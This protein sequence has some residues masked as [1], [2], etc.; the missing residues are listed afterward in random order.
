MNRAAK[1]VLA[2][3]GALYSAAVTARSIG[4]ERQF[5]QTHE[6]R[7]PVISVGNI[8]V[9]GTGKTPLVQWLARRLADGGRTVCILSRGYRRENPKQQIVVSNGETILSDVAH[10]GDEAIMLAQSLIGK[11]AIVCDADRVAGANWAV[12]HLHSRVLLLDDG[13]QH[14]RLARDLDIVTVDASNPFGNERLLPAGILREPIKNLERA[15]CVLLTRSAGLDPELIDRIGGL[16]KAPIFQSCTRIERFRALHSRH[17]VPDASSINTPVAAFCGIGNPRAFFSQLHGSALDVRHEAAFRD[18]H[19]YSQT[20]I[21]QITDKAR[22]N[23]ALAL[24]T[25]AKDAVK[26]ESLSFE[27]PCYVA[28]IEIELSDET[29]LLELV[30]RAIARK[31]NARFAAAG[32]P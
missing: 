18:H 30:E 5:L 25:T 23:G 8:T 14:R 13:F 10:S 32:L 28:D 17:S 27:L 6:V 21:D 1:F 11:S 12:D 16:T 24:I 19:K 20:D 31:T 26:L 4:Y 7:V 9:G 2:P 29:K 22:R 15:D 3:F